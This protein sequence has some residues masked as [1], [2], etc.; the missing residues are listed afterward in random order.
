MRSTR[1]TMMPFI[2]GVVTILKKMSSRYVR[3]GV[4]F[5]KSG[6][7]SELLVTHA[8]MWIS[9]FF[10]FKITTSRPATD[11]CACRETENTS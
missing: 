8:M 9:S 7:Q 6:T 4:I 10:A 2:D 11:C 3:T 5:F 1:I